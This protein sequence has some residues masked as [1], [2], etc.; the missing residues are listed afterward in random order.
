[1]RRTQIT[2]AVALLFAIAASAS[3]QKVTTDY[4]HKA[5][6][7]DYR[8]YKWIRPPQ[9]PGPFMGPRVRDA[10]NSQLAAR[11][12]REV[13]DDSADVGIAAHGANRQARSVQRFYSGYP[14]MWRWGWGPGA[15]TTRVDTYPIGTLVVDIFDARSH[16]I[17]WRSAAR[18]ILSDKPEKNTKKLNK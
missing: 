16:Q 13:A 5:P 9:M 15:V 10:V 17:V 4:D 6:F 7:S 8:T 3:A 1:M 2:L 11:G 18:E 12:W 14:G